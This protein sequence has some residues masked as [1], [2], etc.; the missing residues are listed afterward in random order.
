[1]V[2]VLVG[3]EPPWIIR[4]YYWG[5]MLMCFYCRRPRVLAGGG[6]LACTQRTKEESVSLL[7]Q[8]IRVE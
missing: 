2:H 1:M 4:L 5:Q 8:Q 7:L 3:R 6:G